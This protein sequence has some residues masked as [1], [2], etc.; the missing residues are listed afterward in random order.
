MIIMLKQLFF[1]VLIFITSLTNFAAAQTLPDK[2]TTDAFV[3]ARLVDA[4]KLMDQ[5]FRVPE[6]GQY[7]DAIRIGQE[8][9]AG[10]VSSIAATGIG[11]ASL[12]I[13]DA[14]GVIPDAEQKAIKT[15]SN[16]LS[17]D[18]QS[19]FKVRRS[20]SGWYPHF[21]NPHTGKRS[22]AS[23][24]KFSTIDTALLA[25]GAAI[26]ARYFSAKSFSSGKGESR[27]FMLA[28]RVVGGVRWSSA[29]KS[30]DRGLVHLIFKGPKETQ[31]TNVFA[32]PFDEYALLPCITM[33]GE[34]LAGR[35]GKAHRLFDKH[36]RDASKLPTNDYQGHAVIGKRNGNFIAH[37]THLFVYYYCNNVGNQR[38]YRQALRELSHADRKHFQINGKGSFPSHLWGLGAGSEIKFDENGKV[39]YSA[40]GVNHLGKN[41]HDTASP[42]I[43]AGLAPLF[44]RGEPDDPMIDLYQLWQN[45]LCKYEHKKLEFLWRCSARNP[46]LKVKKVE[47]VDFST[48]LLGLAGRDPKIGMA[49]FRHFDL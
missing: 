9:R 22:K 24:D 35:R 14:L 12:A 26:A 6:T 8:P 15:L 42:A 34:Q 13:G 4:L 25:A 49:F 27:V 3:R 46:S 17:I 40:Y 41:T 19:G 18:R 1:W 32:N 20:A 11:L 21:I 30:V 29:I 48:Y 47:A 28:G 2:K 23:A 44:R 43:M 31:L 38:A 36:Y 39:K 37:F 5:H 45:N 33:R 7:L 16:L 10:D